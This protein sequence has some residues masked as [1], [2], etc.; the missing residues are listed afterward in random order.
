MATIK[1]KIP[2][3]NP[4]VTARVFT[5]SG[6]SYF[7]DSLMLYPSTECDHTRKSI[8]FEVPMFFTARKQNHYF[9]IYKQRGKIIVI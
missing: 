4:A 3:I 9:T 2:P 6:R 5:F 7:K 1:N 8:L